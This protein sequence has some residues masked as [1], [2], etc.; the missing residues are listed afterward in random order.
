MS[1][2][3]QQRKYVLSVGNCQLDHG[4]ISRMI[5]THFNAA[6]DGAA[7]MAAA[8]RQLEQR[9]YDLVLVNRVFDATSEE[10]LDLIRQM[11]ESPALRAIPVMLISNF[12]SAQQEAAAAG[13][14]PGFGKAHLEE[15]QTRAT[16]DAFL[17]VPRA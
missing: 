14:A 6:V 7:D 5:E 3:D 1:S 9:R 2:S 10:G 12:E 11:K 13:A 17:G 16:L 8:L 15:Q 4:S